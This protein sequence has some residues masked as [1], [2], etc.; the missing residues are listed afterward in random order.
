MILVSDW[1][2]HVH[3]TY[4]CYLYKLGLR[5][6]IELAAR[7]PNAEPMT[8]P[9]RTIST[10]RKLHYLVNVTTSKLLLEVTC[11]TYLYMLLI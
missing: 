11:I 10:F 5:P 9:L 1:R 3:V 8:W 6:G 7:C 4:I 2:S